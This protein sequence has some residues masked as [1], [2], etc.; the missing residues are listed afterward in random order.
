MVVFVIISRFR[1]WSNFSLRIITYYN[2]NI[3]SYNLCEDQ[4]SSFLSEC[5]RFN[6]IARA[7]LVPL[8]LLVISEIDFTSV[9]LF[10]PLKRDTEREGEKER[11]ERRRDKT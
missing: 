1:G 11:G 9:L 5:D 4:Y 8:C 6:F 3:F 10:I 2:V 7:P